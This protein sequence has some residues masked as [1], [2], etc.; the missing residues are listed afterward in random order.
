[1][2]S[3]ISSVFCNFHCRNIF[4]FLVLCWVGYIVAFANLFPTLLGLFLE[5]FSFR[6]LWM[7]F[8]SW[9]FSQSSVLYRKGTDFC[10]LILCSATLLNLFIDF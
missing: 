7:G 4:L 9:F 2:F 3:S 5:V 8:C 10:V 1:V 6:L